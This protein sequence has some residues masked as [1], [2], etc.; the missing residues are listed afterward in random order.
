MTFSTLNLFRSLALTGLA[1]SAVSCVSQPAYSP[2]GNVFI[3]DNGRPKYGFQGTNSPVPGA[4]KPAT[5]TTDKPKNTGEDPSKLHD[6]NTNNTPPPTTPDATAG[7]STPSATTG[8]SD[9]VKATKPATGT[10]LPYGTPVIGEK[11]YVYSPYA[12]DKGKVDVKDIPSNTKVE[13]PYTG[14]I[15]RVP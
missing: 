9:D 2:D 13:C 11:G 7:T 10:S 12:P 4:N 3:R 1:F 15:F 5:D 6:G 8:G 14:K